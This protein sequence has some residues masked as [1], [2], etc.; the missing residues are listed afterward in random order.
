MLLQVREFI[1]EIGHENLNKRLI[2]SKEGKV[3]FEKPKMTID[4]L[5]SYGN[6]LVSEQDNVKRVQLADAYLAGAELAGS[7]GSSVPES[8]SGAKNLNLGKN[9]ASSRGAGWRTTGQ[10]E[11][12]KEAGAGRSPAAPAPTPAAA[13]APSNGGDRW[14]SYSRGS[15]PAPAAGGRASSGQV[16]KPCSVWWWAGSCLSQHAPARGLSLCRPAR[17]STPVV[18]LMCQGCLKA[19]LL[20]AQGMAAQQRLPLF[21]HC[22]SSC[23]PHRMGYCC[24]ILACRF[25]WVS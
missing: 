1:T 23:R 15:S 16:S 8:Y 2:N 25:A 19:M 20:T 6:A 18:A 17:Q 5:M 21:K 24:Y 12:A 13:P 14:A 9:N 10:R 11:A 3:K 7:D 22:S 4:V